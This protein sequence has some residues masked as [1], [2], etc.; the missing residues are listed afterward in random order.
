[1]YASLCVVSSSSSEDTRNH[2]RIGNLGGIGCVLR[3]QYATM[4]L[5]RRTSGRI[6]HRPHPNLVL[7]PYTLPRQAVSSAAQQRHTSEENEAPGPGAEHDTRDRDTAFVSLVIHPVEKAKHVKTGRPI[8]HSFRVIFFISVSCVRRA[9]DVIFFWSSITPRAPQ[10][11]VCPQ[12]NKPGP[13]SHKHPTL[14][15]LPISLP[16]LHQTRHTHTHHH[17]HHHHHHHTF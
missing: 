13:P 1:M 4:A 6:G 16:V 17:H 7:G 8:D 11:F 14:F 10:F 3:R 2:T 15:R 9:A 12:A 5:P